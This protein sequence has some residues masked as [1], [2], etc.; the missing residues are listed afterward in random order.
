MT[1][2]VEAVA[3]EGWAA[4]GACACAA[5]V[6]VVFSDFFSGLFHWSADNYGS[7]ATPVFGGVVE[8][9]QGHHD[10]P[11]TI[12]HRSF[13][14]N[15]H[16]IALG[17]LVLLPLAMAAS[18]APA[19]RIFAVVFFN[20]QILCQEFHKFS[21]MVKPPAAATWLQSQGWAISRKEHGLHHSS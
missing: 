12:T 11:Y 13:F 19:W 6:S 2:V 21:H 20:A 5:A 9:F 10:T 14:N 16:K 15:V 4:V 3:G 18:A 1:P 17:V 8:A 7:K